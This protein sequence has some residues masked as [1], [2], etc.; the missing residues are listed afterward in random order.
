MCVYSIKMQRTW[1]RGDPRARARG[2]GGADVYEAPNTG[3][4]SVCDYNYRIMCV[5]PDGAGGAIRA[6]GRENVFLCCEATA[7]VQVEKF[8]FQNFSLVL[9]WTSA[10]F[11][12]CYSGPV[13]TYKCRQRFVAEVV[14]V[15]S[16]CECR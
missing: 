2:S 3:P 12:L 11:N 14:V 1:A 10:T 6:H 4:M 15:I 8:F 7:E 16:I 13:G 9:P 5:S